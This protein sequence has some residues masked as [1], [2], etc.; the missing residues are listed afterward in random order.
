MSLSFDT[1]DRL[2]RNPLDI[3]QYFVRSIIVDPTS[4]SELRLSYFTRSI[5]KDPDANFSLL[6]LGW[7]ASLGPA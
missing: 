5:R 7:A 6:A 4:A 2:T 1:N 3:V